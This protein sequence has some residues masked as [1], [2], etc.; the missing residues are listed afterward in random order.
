MAT[1][2]SEN[3]HHRKQATK[4]LAEGYLSSD[5]AP[6]KSCIETLWAVIRESGVR[7]S[8]DCVP[9]ET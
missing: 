4:E 9:S 8:V 6:G 5:Q 7:E 3:T 1:E 2:A